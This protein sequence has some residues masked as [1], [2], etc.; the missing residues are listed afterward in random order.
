MKPTVAHQLVVKP[1]LSWLDS[2]GIKHSP[3]AECMVLAAGLQE[4]KL[5]AR[6]QIVRAKPKGKIG[7]ATGLWQF[8]REGGVKGVLSHSA[9]VTVARRVCE[10]LGVRPER[11][12]VWEKLVEFDLLAC[13]FARLLLWTDPQKLPPVKVGAEQEAW[14]YYI[15]CW[16]PGKPHRE[17]WGE[18]W[19]TAVSVVS[20]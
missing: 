15:R 2:Y 13:A 3:E 14:D 10:E 1:V 20:N 16:R 7:P 11:Q 19:K 6:D 18:Y 17:T 4:S 5:K 8:E 12:I 9:T